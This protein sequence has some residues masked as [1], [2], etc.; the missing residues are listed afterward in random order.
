MFVGMV[1]GRVVR[2]PTHCHNEGDD[3]PQAV[4]KAIRRTYH[5]TELHGISDE[6]FYGRA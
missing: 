3:E 1:D 5:L 2:Y 4:I 6:E